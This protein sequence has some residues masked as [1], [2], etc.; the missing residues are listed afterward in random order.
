MADWVAAGGQREPPRMP[1]H[2]EIE[3]AMEKIG[4]ID[5]AHGFWVIAFYAKR[6]PAIHSEILDLRLRGDYE[7]VLDIVQKDVAR[8]SNLLTG[9][10]SDDGR[11]YL[12]MVLNFRA[13]WFELRA[14][15][16]QIVWQPNA[17]AQD[18]LKQLAKDDKNAQLAHQSPETDYD[19][20]QKKLASLS[21]ELEEVKD[22][23]SKE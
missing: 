7:A 22:L 23:V 11:R 4:E 21:N 20:I 12:N 16:E 2:S 9:D 3:N 8:L 17:K 19:K 6:N 5:K 18:H 10:S 1:M 14:S 15:G 13:T